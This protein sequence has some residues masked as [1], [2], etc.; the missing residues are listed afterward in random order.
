MSKTDTE[1]IA[2]MAAFQPMPNEFPTEARGSE[3][4]TAWYNAQLWLHQ[5]ARGEV[6]HGGRQPIDRST[7]L[8]ADYTQAERPGRND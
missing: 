6:P 2:E 3:G 8:H 5:A 4:F 7:P 1:Y